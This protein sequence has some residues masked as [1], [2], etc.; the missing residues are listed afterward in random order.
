MGKNPSI[1]PCAGSVAV[2]C[3]PSA[4]KVLDRLATLP[5]AVPTSTPTESPLM[6]IR[7]AKPPVK[8]K[9]VPPPALSYWV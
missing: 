1:K 2:I 3:I 8:V 6:R 5:G 9:S 7:S 4:V